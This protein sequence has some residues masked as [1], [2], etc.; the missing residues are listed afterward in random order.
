MAFRISNSRPHKMQKRIAAFDD[1]GEDDSNT[2]SSSKEASAAAQASA[3]AWIVKG[4]SFAESGRSAAALRCWDQ[5]A[6]I[7]PND[8]KVHE[9]RAQ[10]LNSLDRTFEA[11]QA[12]QQAVQLNP[13]WPEAHI[14]LARIQLNLGEPQLAL[15]SYQAAARLQPD[16]PDLVH[17]LPTV[18]M[19]AK[20][21]QQQ[22]AG[23]RAHVIREGA[24]GRVARAAA[25][26]KAA[27]GGHVGADAGEHKHSDEQFESQEAERS[28]QAPA[29]AETSGHA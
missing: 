13:H 15:Q 3:Q 10:V 7:H 4:S 14:T 11:V 21:H 16:H 20:L 29:A 1:T 18:Q 28:Q 8:P 17:E 27:E 2:D 12:A 26:A 9:M 23:S 19:Y 22:P 25:Q 24:S 5:A 6:L